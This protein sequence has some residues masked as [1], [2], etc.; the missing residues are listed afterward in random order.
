MR[1]HM[2]VFNIWRHH[3]F[4]KHVLNKLIHRQVKE[5]CDAGLYERGRSDPLVPCTDLAAQFV[6]VNAFEKATAGTL[7]IKRPF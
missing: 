4:A 3:A 7:L 1:L 6:D 2:V 5:P